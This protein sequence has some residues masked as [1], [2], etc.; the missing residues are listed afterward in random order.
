L[1]NRLGRLEEVH[2]LL[3]ECLDLYARFGLHPPPGQCTDPVIGLGMLALH[4]GNHAE[5]ARL[6]EQACRRAE[7][8]QHDGN[9]QVIYYLLARTARAQGQYAKARDYAGRAYAA[10]QRTQNRYFAAFCHNE[11]GMIASLEGRYAE[12]QHHYVAAHTIREAFNDIQGIAADLILLGKVAVLEERFGDAQGLFQRSL[13]ICEATGA[14]DFAVRALHGLGVTACALRDYGAAQQAVGRAL[15]I[16]EAAGFHSLILQALT[17]GCALLIAS[18][19]PELAAEL[20]VYV[21]RHP[22]TDR[23]TSDAAQALLVGCEAVVDTSDLVTTIER[24]QAL[25]L[26][27]AVERLR[28]DLTRMSEVRSDTTGGVQNA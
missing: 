27:R 10:V 21:L 12:A 24:G 6:G 28:M 2:T 17:G 22:A 5:A 20:L 14:R 15:Q 9:L 26:D 25:T 11:L 3:E 8:Q 16:A 19:Q 7:E 18:G 1:L 23:E 13:A 4:Q